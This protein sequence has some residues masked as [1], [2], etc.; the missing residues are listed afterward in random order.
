MTT[1]LRSEALADSLKQAHTLVVELMERV[2]QLSLELRPALLDDLGLLPSLLWYLDRYSS[3]T[4]VKAIFKHSGLENRRFAPEIE[5]AAYRII[6]EALTNVARHARVSETWVTL[7]YDQDVL[8]IQVEDE[9]QGFDPDEVLA[10]GN[11][12]GLLGMQ[13]RALLLNG[14]LTIESAQG[15]GTRLLAELP[16]SSTSLKET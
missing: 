1:K 10:A 13:E 2:S 12:S 6:Q 3:Q 4:N 9:G 15:M 11:S 5:T 7:W 14:K 8:G 16:V